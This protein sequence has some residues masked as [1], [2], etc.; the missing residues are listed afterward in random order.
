MTAFRNFPQKLP[1]IGLPINGI[2]LYLSFEVPDVIGYSEESK[3][4]F[5]IDKCEVVPHLKTDGGRSRSQS[6]IVN[7]AKYLEFFYEK[8]NLKFIFQ[9]NY[10]ESVLTFSRVKGEPR[11]QRRFIERIASPQKSLN[12]KNF[13][14]RKLFGPLQ[15][16]FHQIIELQIFS[17]N[18]DFWR[19]LGGAV[20]NFC[21][22]VNGSALH[23]IRQKSSFGMK[24]VF[25]PIILFI[26]NLGKDGGLE[27]LRTSTLK[28]L[29]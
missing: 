29:F 25:Q 23:P 14:S 3:K 13:R 22:I 2:Q 20:H 1:I 5:S 17:K 8:K 27:K 7:A 9:S 15:T 16:F 11:T 28:T 4:A 19:N 10:Y 26:F 24:K 21:Q 18:L 6:E 12:Y